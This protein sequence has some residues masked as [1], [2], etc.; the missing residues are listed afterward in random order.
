MLSVLETQSVLQSCPADLSFHGLEKSD[1][2]GDFRGDF[3]GSRGLRLRRGGWRDLRVSRSP[4][5][6]PPQ[7]MIRRLPIRS[8]VAHAIL[9][10]SPADTFFHASRRTCS[11]CLN[12]KAARRC[13][14]REGVFSLR[15]SSANRGWPTRLAPHP[16]G[17]RSRA[18]SPVRNAAAEAYRIRSPRAGAAR[19][20]RRALLSDR[21]RQPARGSAGGSPGPGATHPRSP[22][23][24]ARRRRPPRLRRAANATVS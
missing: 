23:Q 15:D 22:S 9:P 1:F 14:R 5:P 24:A 2:R 21:T 16:P 3:L 10:W 6:N 17:F 19:A 20:R 11:R 7:P 12:L 8:V 18:S 13:V 4:S